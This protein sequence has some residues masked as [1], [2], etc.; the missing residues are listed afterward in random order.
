MIEAHIIIRLSKHD[1]IVNLMD[2]YVNEMKSDILNL[3][4]EEQ[5]KYWKNYNLVKEYIDNTHQVISD[6]VEQ[7]SSM[8][9]KQAIRDNQ[10]YMLKLKKYIKELGGDLSLTHYL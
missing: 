10:L 4:R 3:P 5:P 6:L 7:L 2:R 1:D 9:S 8:P